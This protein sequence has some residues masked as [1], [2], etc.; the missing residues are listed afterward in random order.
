MGKAW[1]DEEAE[2]L[3]IRWFTIKDYLRERSFRHYRTDARLAMDLRRLGGRSDRKTISGSKTSLWI[4]PAS[5]RPDHE[6][7]EPRI[8][9]QPTF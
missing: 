3:W 9:P 7:Y 8:D 5:L 6:D 4:F 2:E 1:H